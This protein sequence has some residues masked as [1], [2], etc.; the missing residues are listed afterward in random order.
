MACVYSAYVVGVCGLANTGCLL[1][2]GPRV[3]ATITMNDP[4]NA[5]PRAP[6]ARSRRRRGGRAGEPQ[7]RRASAA[8]KRC[9]IQRAIKRH[10]GVQNSTV[11]GVRALFWGARCSPR[12]LQGYSTT[13]GG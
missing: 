5:T 11:R 4:P 1:A 3:A 2:M 12:G 10:M 8:R 13:R 6:H 9:K 7:Q